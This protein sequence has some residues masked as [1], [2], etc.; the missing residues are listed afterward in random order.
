MSIKLSVKL[1]SYTTTRCVYCI[2]F[3]FYIYYRN[4]VTL[5][6]GY[7]SMVNVTRYIKL[8][9]IQYNETQNI[10]NIKTRNRYLFNVKHWTRLKQTC[11]F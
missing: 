11:V 4:I 8:K 10:S 2:F 7:I 5:L 3:T 9:S 1:T 6:Y